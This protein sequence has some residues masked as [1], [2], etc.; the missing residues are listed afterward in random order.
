MFNNC[1]SRVIH[2]LI[3]HR[4]STVVDISVLGVK[5]GKML[6]ASTAIFN[7]F[8]LSFKQEKSEAAMNFE[9]AILANVLIQIV[10]L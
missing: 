9:F 2:V 10:H 3:I 8:T 7:H 6:L 1:L 5:H 4:M